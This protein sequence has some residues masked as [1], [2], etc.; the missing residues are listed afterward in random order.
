[1]IAESPWGGQDDDAAAFHQLFY[2]VHGLLRSDHVFQNVR[3][4]N[5]ISR[6][7]GR[8][9]F[10]R[11]FRHQIEDHVH[12]RL[13]ASINMND[14]DPFFTQRP[15]QEVFDVRLLQNPVLFRT[16]AEVED[17]LAGPQREPH[18]R[19]SLHVK[20]YGLVTPSHEILLREWFLPTL[21]DSYELRIKECPQVGAMEQ[22]L[23]GTR[24]F[25]QT[26]WFKVNWILEAI[27]E[28][29]GSAFVCSDVDIQFFRK[30]E[31]IISHLLQSNDLVF[32]REDPAGVPCCGFFCCRANSRTLRFWQDVLK[33]MGQ[34][35]AQ[36]EQKV[37]SE[38]L[39]PFLALYPSPI[40]QILARI[41]FLLMQRNP[42]GLRWDY[43]P[44][45]F[46]GGGTLTGTYWEPG[47]T[48][49]VPER[50]VMHHANWTFGIEN[51]ISQL[52]YV[53]S[54]VKPSCKEDRQDL[55]DLRP[56]GGLR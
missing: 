15:K 14:P 44:N 29:W 38:I 37:A 28:T 50:I 39:R 3:A 32:Q 36:N 13:P 4:E 24:E 55:R 33:R 23:F 46:F 12:S 19:P 1:M 20:L 21:A 9:D 10:L 5:H 11:G 30:T 17:G 54:V 53:R 40:K 6:S 56:S 41:R 22:H 52:R 16:G 8:K 45:E 35:P 18:G 31:P 49:P 43:L 2:P 42:Y 48:L 27:R 7:D 25:V 51:K 47:G 34:P 26:V